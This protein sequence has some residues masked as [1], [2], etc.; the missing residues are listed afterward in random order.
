VCIE[1]T[2]ADGTLD[3]LMCPVHDREFSMQKRLLAST[4]IFEGL[5]ALALTMSITKVALAE[6][7]FDSHGR[8]I[9]D[10]EAWSLG[11][12]RLTDVPSALA[13]TIYD[14]SSDPMTNVAK[15]TLFVSDSNGLEGKGAIAL[16]GIAPY[17]TID[18]SSLPSSFDGRRVAYRVW[19][20]PRGTRIVFDIYTYTGDYAQASSTGNWSG[21]AFAGMIGFRPTGR[22]T[23]DGWEEWSTGPVDFLAGGLARPAMLTMTDEQAVT[24]QTSYFAGYD[25]GARA[26]VDA[27]EIVD[28]GPALV[29]PSPCRL[30][31][32]EQVCGPQG[33]CLYGRCVDSKYVEGTPPAPSHVEDYVQRRRNEFAAF[34]G[35]RLPQSL[36]GAFSSTLLALAS[37]PTDARFFPTIRRAVDDLR[38]GHASAPY[39]SYSA[40]SSAGI[41]AHLG[42]ADL[43]PSAE[44]LPLVFS[45]GQSNPISDAVMPGD[46]L[47]AIDGL[48]P[49]LW[50][51]LAFRSLSYGGDPA[52]RD[53]ILAP[54][55]IDAA[56]TAG[57]VLTFAT[58]QTSV[59]EP[60]ACAPGE[61]IS[62]DIDT[63][64]LLGDLMWAGAAPTWRAERRA[65][66]FRFRRPVES[67]DVLEYDF[68]G[69]ATLD[70]GIEALLIN[71]VPSSY[72]APHWHQVVRGFVDGEKP[73]LLLD[74]RTGHGGSIE[75]VDLLAGSLLDHT[76]FSHLELHPIFDVPLTDEIRSALEHCED[77]FGRCGGG[78][79]WELG[80]SLVEEGTASEARL[81]VLMA[82]DVSGNDY[83]TRL[84]KER[85][86]PTRIF[87]AGA[88]YGAFGVIWTLP[89]IHHELLG[90]S[91]QVHDT[92][93][94]KAADDADAEFSTGVGVIPDEIVL[95]RQSD[96]RAGVDT[97]L[98]RA[99]AWLLD[100]TTTEP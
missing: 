4:H 16:G 40:G 51:E 41:C 59:S 91:F 66:D 99:S 79:W 87:G 88:T 38:D 85:N 49:T 14:T 100:G 25:I 11:L 76:E 54:A 58:C 42:E 33:V 65:C 5:L 39:V 62:V 48:P 95:Q 13:L 98:A 69:T 32:E 9:L 90:G 7:T 60:V 72:E 43:L 31:D 53:V 55:H 30:V 17:A 37:A 74:E 27:F 10:D 61:E 47:I 97:A 18:L 22:V 8:L 20:R 26:L 2:H 6:S 1:S 89:P 24:M 21:I 28:L 67:A 63:R 93:F 35:G 70:G 34:E 64:S 81:A 45:V 83:V 94:L 57:S 77:D 56:L 52:A 92:L 82:K 75:A 23:S 86:A 36:M 44:L 68:A 19:Q 96:A 15:S 73:L 12:D 50:A 78:I 46:A 80:A 84:L 71:G 3:A 29:P